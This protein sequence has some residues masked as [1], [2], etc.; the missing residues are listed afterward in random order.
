MAINTVNLRIV[1]SAGHDKKRDHWN[2]RAK[3]WLSFLCGRTFVVNAMLKWWLRPS[4]RKKFFSLHPLCV[5]EALKQKVLLNIPPTSIRHLMVDWIKIDNTVLHTNDYFIGS[6]EWNEI[7]RDITT[8]PILKEAKEMLQIN[9]RFCESES[10]KR[11]T[12]AIQKGKPLKRQHVVLDSTEKINTYFLRFQKLY[13]SIMQ[14]G[15]LSHEKLQGSN[16]RDIGIA[17]DKDGSFI[18]LPG[19]QHRFAL[20][21]TM[22]IESIPVEIRMVHREFLIRHGLST[23]EKIKQFFETMNTCHESKENELP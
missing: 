1:S 5:S 10:Y 7:K 21:Y 18:K 11:Y 2:I 8:F 15:F 4:I 6:G 3:K 23:L 17:I 20:A 13:Y 14:H 9:W 16:N 19:G 22:G 12:A